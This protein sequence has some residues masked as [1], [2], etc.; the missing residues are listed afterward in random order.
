[1]QSIKFAAAAMLALSPAV[2]FAQEFKDFEGAINDTIPF[3]TLDSTLGRDNVFT[4]DT[5]WGSAVADFATDRIYIP[6]GTGIR[7]YSISQQMAL[8]G[9]SARSLSSIQALVPRDIFTSAT[10][11][12]DFG[13]CSLSPCE[14]HY[15]V[16]EGKYVWTLPSSDDGRPVM[17]PV[18]F[19]KLTG[20][21]RDYETARKQRCEDF[22]A[23]LIGSTLETPAVGS[24]C[25]VN[26]LLGGAGCVGG[27]S[28]QLWDAAERY[29][30]AS[31]C[32]SSYPGPGK[33]NGSRLPVNY[34][35]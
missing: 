11:A 15:D 14:S 16:L 4:A 13:P 21:I 23:S 17:D 34:G 32:D 29:R 33:W 12:P 6:T 2:A 28:K 10:G 3:A 26:T 31:D 9:Y 5:T 8:A 24:A 1:M 7:E 18:V 22:R 20:D 19:E 35:K 30:A 25:W 27:L